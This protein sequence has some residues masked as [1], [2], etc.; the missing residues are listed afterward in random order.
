MEPDE[1]ACGL[2]DRMRSRS[3]R[4]MVPDGEPPPSF[5]RVDLQQGKTGRQMNRM[6]P[7]GFSIWARSK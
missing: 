3:R 7:S 2:D 1:I 6:R 5:G 4:E